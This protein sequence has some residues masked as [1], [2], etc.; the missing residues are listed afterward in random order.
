SVEITETGLNLGGAV[1]LAIPAVIG[2]KLANPD[3]QV[4]GIIGDGA[5]LMSQTELFTAAHLNIGAI[6]TIFNDGELAQISQA[7]QTPYNKKT[8][9]VLPNVKFEAIAH[10]SGCQYLRIESNDDV[11]EKLAQAISYAQDN[12]P[13]VLDVNIDYSKKTRFTQGIITTNLKRMK[14]PTKVRMISRAL[15]RR[16]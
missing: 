9:T 4:V 8:C 11:S 2:A 3:N 13:V 12:T 14:L 10:A 5:F 7:Q 6:F 1:G 15:W 16:V